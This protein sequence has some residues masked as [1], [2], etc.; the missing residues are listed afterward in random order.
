MHYSDSL[1]MSYSSYMFRRRYVTSGSLL[2]C[3]L[4]SYIKDAY[5]FIVCIAVCTFSGSN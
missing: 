2:L 5:G 1:L 4:L 3:V